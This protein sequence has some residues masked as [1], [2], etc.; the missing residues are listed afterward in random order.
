[1][2]SFSTHS[3]FVLVA[4]RAA[5]LK[6]LAAVLKDVVPRSDFTSQKNEFLV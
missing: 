1:M 4:I 3:E 5:S 2:L 6:F